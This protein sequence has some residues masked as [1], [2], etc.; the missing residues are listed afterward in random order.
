MSVKT[1]GRSSANLEGMKAGVSNAALFMT[2]WAH[3][4]LPGTMIKR[5]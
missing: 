5:I 4:G 1:I 3:R 2:V